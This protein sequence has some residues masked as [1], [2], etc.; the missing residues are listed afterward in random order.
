M[1]LIKITQYT[2]FYL[3]GGLEMAGHLG[4]TF[5]IFIV[6]ISRDRGLHIGR[7]ILRIWS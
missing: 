4:K 2:E 7:V 1:L 6:D 3:E 5:Y